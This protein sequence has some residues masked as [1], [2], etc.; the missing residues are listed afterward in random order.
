MID[1][2]QVVILINIL[3]FMKYE[4]YD[5]DNYQKFKFHDIYHI[6]QITSFELK[7]RIPP[8]LQVP[9]PIL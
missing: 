4:I 1:I 3:S 5:C 9:F 7:L 8:F 6:F 2:Y